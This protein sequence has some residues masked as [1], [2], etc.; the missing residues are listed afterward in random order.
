[1]FEAAIRV[2]PSADRSVL[3]DRLLAQ[4]ACELASAS[5]P[6]TDCAREAP[7][8]TVKSFNVILAGF[9]KEVTTLPRAVEK[10]GG[11]G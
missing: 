9:C 3:R 5:D 11:N 10:V 6:P 7:T 2:M 4:E 8:W 1:M